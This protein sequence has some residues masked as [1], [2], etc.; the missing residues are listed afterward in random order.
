MVQMALLVE[1]RAEYPDVSRVDLCFLLRGAHTT[2]P[3]QR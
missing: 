2:S 1:V 3:P